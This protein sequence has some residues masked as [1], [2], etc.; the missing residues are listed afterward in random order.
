MVKEGRISFISPGV[1]TPDPVCTN[2]ED[3]ITNYRRGNSF[4]KKNFGLESIKIQTSWLT[5]TF[6]FSME[7]SR[8]LNEMGSVNQITD[9]ISIDDDQSELK[10]KILNTALSK[11][12]LKRISFF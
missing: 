11:I 9:A 4:L 3:L 8:L 1:S 12:F 6:G 2:Y 10:G 5:D 7:L